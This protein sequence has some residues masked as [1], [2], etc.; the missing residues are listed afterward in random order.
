MIRCLALKRVERLLYDD[1]MALDELL[2]D[3]TKS[4]LIATSESLGNPQYV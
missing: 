3:G 2:K 4:L 1:R